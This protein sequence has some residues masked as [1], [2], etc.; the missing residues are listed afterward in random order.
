VNYCD[1]SIE[2]ALDQNNLA[3][4][5]QAYYYDT[6]SGTQIAY[7][8]LGEVEGT[9]VYQVDAG[10]TQVFEIPLSA[11]LSAVE[12]PTPVLSVAYGDMSTSQ[13]SISGANDTMV[14]P[15][16]WTAG[17]GLVKVA[18]GED[19]KTLIITI[20]GADLPEQAPF[21]IAMPSGNNKYYSSLRIRGTGV[22]W[23]KKLFTFK[24]GENADLAPD[25]VG[26]VVDNE[27]METFDQMYHRILLTAERFS[28]DKYTISVTS[29]G[30]NRLGESGS[31]TYPTIGRVAATYPGATI[32]S[33][34]SSLGPTIADWN[35]TLFAMVSSDFTNQA[36][37]NVAGARVK[38]DQCWFRIRSA[39][40][41]PRTINYGAERDNTIGDVYTT[42]ET[43]AQWNTRWAGKTIRDVNLAP[44]IA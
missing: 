23:E 38:Y 40:I 13:Y 8:V 18:I 35:A 26:V 2:W 9:Q 10:E 4:S 21:R 42:G 32:S 20:R 1:S 3:R 22:F 31:V 17:G 28:G 25:E 5:V 12:Q 30:I 7:P 11:S 39:T 15:G 24:I 44:L 19:T 41:T 6:T 33:I 36:F 27:F 37:G 29:G 14:D 43:I 34:Y 16:L